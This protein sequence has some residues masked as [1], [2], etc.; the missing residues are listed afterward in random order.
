VLVSVFAT[1]K[2]ITLHAGQSFLA[3]AFTKKS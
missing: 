3:S 1:R 2:T